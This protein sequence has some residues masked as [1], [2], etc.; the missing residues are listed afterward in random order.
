[1]IADRVGWQVEVRDADDGAKLIAA[2]RD[3]GEFA[4]TLKYIVGYYRLQR[5][6]IVLSAIDKDRKQVIT[7]YTA[8]SSRRSLARPSPWPST[9]PTA[10]FA[11]P[12]P[13]SQAKDI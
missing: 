5:L 10:A 9:H 6:S 11:L 8:D 7:C 4:Q 13:V 3:D 12:C 1:V 2:A